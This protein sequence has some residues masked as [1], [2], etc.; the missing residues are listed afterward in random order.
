MYLYGA[1]GVL[2]EPNPR[3]AA[4]LRQMRAGDEVIEAGISTTGQ[5]SATLIRLTA[6]VY[7]T[8]DE[9]NAAHV[10][11][12]SAHWL[13]ELRQE[14]VDRVAVRTTSLEGILKTR[15]AEFSPDFMSIDAEGDDYKI[16]SSMNLQRWRPGIICVEA[17]GH[18]TPQLLEANGYEMIALTPDN[19][20]YKLRR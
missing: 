2:V 12:Q 14:I 15:F 6:D 5:T 13:P 19:F 3:Y 10:V 8:F 18:E 17:S 4:K 16:L 20:V 1:R 11:S 9:A 7:N